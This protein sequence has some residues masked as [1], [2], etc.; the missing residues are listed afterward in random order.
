MQDTT[1]KV[2][3]LEMLAKHPH[4]IYKWGV[5]RAR[6]VFLLYSHIQ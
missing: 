6:I 2:D 3:R 5:S 4:D 1:R